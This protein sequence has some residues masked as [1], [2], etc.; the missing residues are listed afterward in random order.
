MEDLYR[1]HIDTVE[2]RTEKDALYINRLLNKFSKQL[3]D[4]YK[5]LLDIPCGYGR[6]HKILRSLGYNVYGVDISNEL[7]N[8]AIQ[9]YP[10]YK[11]NYFV[12]DMRSSSFD[13][14]FDVVIN[15]FSSFG[16]M[17]DKENEITLDNFNRNLRNRGLLLMETYNGDLTL[18]KLSKGKIINESYHDK[19]KEIT[20]NYLNK[21]DNRFSLME[22]LFYDSEKLIEKN[23]IKIRV[24]RPK[25]IKT[26]LTRHGFRLLS[27]YKTYTFKNY[28]IKDRRLTFVAI[29]I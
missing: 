8:K 4:T 3:N 25:E 19:I 27:I 10:E 20:I 1:W 15:W 29:K 21:R 12:G 18:Q 11:S 16:Y 24:Y 26:L 6:H 22:E 2:Y 7:I 14:S 28:S 17:S 13:F 23:K 9:T 5:N